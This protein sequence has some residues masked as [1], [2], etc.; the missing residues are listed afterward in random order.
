MA[1]DTVLLKICNCTYLLNSNNVI[2]RLYVKEKNLGICRQ[3]CKNKDTK[4]LIHA[5][6]KAWTMWDIQA[7]GDDF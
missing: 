4:F 6:K 1:V 2:I 5:W 3:R 7:K